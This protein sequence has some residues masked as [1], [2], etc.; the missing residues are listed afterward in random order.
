MV[1]VVQVRRYHQ[2]HGDCRDG[3]SRTKII[4][5][6]VVVRHYYNSSDGTGNTEMVSESHA[7]WNIKW[8]NGE[9]IDIGGTWMGVYVSVVCFEYILGQRNKYGDGNGGVFMEPV[10]DAWPGINRYVNVMGSMDTEEVCVLDGYR[11]GG[12]RYIKEIWYLGG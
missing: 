10:V 9:Y 1:Y 5:E 8:F 2:I 3:D 7:W 11:V 12:I 4:V 6:M